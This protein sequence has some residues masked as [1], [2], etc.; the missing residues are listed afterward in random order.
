MKALFALLLIGV[1]AFG[2]YW[3]LTSERDSR[4]L[5]RVEDQA[6]EAARD[7]K[8]SV[9]NT[10]DDLSLSVPKIKEELQRAGKVV[11]KKSEELRPVVADAMADA[12][13]TTEIKAKLTKDPNLSAL[14]ISVDTT[15]G[16]VTLSGS[17][18]SE[19][20]IAQA[21]RLAMETEGV[22]ETVSTLQVVADK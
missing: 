7:V 21:M 13:I 14:R 20:E 1:L 11:R 16:V 8:E 12:R 6:T 22:R 18:D 9:R 3:Y 2:A 15:E 4:G 17:V 19:E 10:V 5:Q